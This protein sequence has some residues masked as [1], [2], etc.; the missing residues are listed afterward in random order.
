[1]NLTLLTASDLDYYYTNKTMTD[2]FS[3]FFI[4]IAI[5]VV[6]IML[7]YNVTRYRKAP[8]A[9]RR[10]TV[11]VLSI[12]LTVIDTLFLLLKIDIL[13]FLFNPYT[14]L[15]TSRFSINNISDPQAKQVYLIVYI[16]YVAV[17]IL[18]TIVCVLGYRSL[19]NKKLTQDAFRQE[20]IV[21]PV[22]PQFKACAI[23]GVVTHHQAMCCPRCSSTQFVSSA[24]NQNEDNKSIC[25]SCHTVNS[26]NATFCH[27][28]GY[29]IKNTEQ[30]R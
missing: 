14:Y 6:A 28:C 11:K 8:N 13:S 10:T 1:M 29:K 2:L 18:S 22:N 12:I 17:L 3:G 7:F 15:T 26:E 24:D 25:P 27:Y 21:V 20:K 9:R 30:N 5:I 19:C 4:F 23:C 16:V